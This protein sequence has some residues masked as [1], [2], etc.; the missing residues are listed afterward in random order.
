M[1][2]DF[3]AMDGYEFEDYIS[4]LFRRLGFEVE[5]T[6]YSNDGGVDLIA[7]FNQPIF[8]GKYIIKGGF[9]CA[10]LACSDCLL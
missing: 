9:L 10:A 6:N 4:N 8:S 5:P 3:S 7:T 2:V 1:N